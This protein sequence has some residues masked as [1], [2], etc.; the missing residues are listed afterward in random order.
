M[1][2]RIVKC[3]PCMPVAMVM[4]TVA[5]IAKGED[6]GVIRRDFFQS[7]RT[8]ILVYSLLQRP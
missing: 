4:P 5:A 8:L 1:K 6:E 3:T 7:V 2:G